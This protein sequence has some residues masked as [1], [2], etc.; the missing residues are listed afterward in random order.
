MN[1]SFN[2]FFQFNK[3]AVIGDAD[4]FADSFRAY[5][6][7]FGHRSPGIGTELLDA[8]GNAV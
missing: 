6:V 1:Q 5:R 2:T 4:N 7:A 3:D 8:K